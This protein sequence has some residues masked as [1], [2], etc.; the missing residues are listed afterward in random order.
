M[1]NSEIPKDVELPSSARLIKSS[2]FA[3]VS[4]GVILVTCILPAEYAIDPTG[5]GNVLGL[6]KMGDIKQSLEAENAE[7]VLAQAVGNVGTAS[8]MHAGTAEPTAEVP[9][10]RKDSI[11]ID[12]QPG[13]ATE[14]KLSMPKDASVNYEWRTEG[15]G[16]NFD[17]HGDA[18]GISYHGYGKGRNATQQQGTL[19]AAFDGKHGWFW[20]NRTENPV[21]I[22]LSVEGQFSEMKKV[23]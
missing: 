19:I 21:K 6:K 2:V 4:A 16:V 15:G 17:T 12:L 11:S 13:Q 3:L 14:V 22:V 23:L 7:N 10:V 20:R 8:K 18:V 1:Y 9:A 5:I